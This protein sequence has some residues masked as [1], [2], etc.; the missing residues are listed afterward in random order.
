[1]K[2]LKTLPILLLLLSFMA[3]KKDKNNQ[4]N[5]SSALVK[6]AA[7]T[8]ANG[9][10][11]V[12]DYTYDSEKRLIGYGNTPYK[13]AYNAGGILLSYVEGNY[14]VYNQISLSNGRI[15]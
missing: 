7:T 14:E 2:T 10:R 3:C 4:Q 8:Y 6:Q 1:M 12:I 13:F 15:A 5:L 11:I 9:N